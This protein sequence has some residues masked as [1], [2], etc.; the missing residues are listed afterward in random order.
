M[1]WLGDGVNAPLVIVRAVHFAATA[2][3]AGTLIFR[4]VVAERASRSA[5]AAI[6]VVR[7]QILRVAWISLAIAA[8]SGAVWILLQAAAMSGLS[9]EEAIAG[10][11]LSVVVNQTQFGL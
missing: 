10:D 2:T 4:A 6:A 9:L 1:D 7:S 3:T 8:L 5:P 11:A